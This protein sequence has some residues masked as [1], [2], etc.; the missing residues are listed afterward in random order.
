[1]ICPSCGEKLTG[2]L[3]HCTHC[4]IAITARSA[5][6]AKMINNG[7]WVARRA[8]GGF[9]AGGIGWIFAIAVSRTL[10]FEGASSATFLD[11]LNFFPGRE[12]MATAIAG[13]FIGTVGGMI[14]RSAYKSCLGGFLGAVGGAL[15]G[16]AHPALEEIFRGQLYSY[17]FSMACSWG[18]ASALVGL[19]SGIMEGSKKKVVAGLAGGLV[20]GI[21]G[22]GIGSQM[23]GAMLM[24]VESLEKFSWL[25]ARLMEFA[26]GGIV[27]VNVWMFIGLA[28]KFYI[29]RRRVLGEA[30]SK[31]CDYCRAENG[32]NAWYCAE[33]GSALQVA[34]SR[35]QMKV[36][37]YR[38]LE[39]ISNAFQYLSWLSATAGVVAALVIFFSF[40]VQ[41]FLFALFGSLLMA[42]IVYMATV[43][44]KSAADTI[45]LG[46]QI[47]EKLG[48]DL[49]P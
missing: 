4:G 30:S 47:G 25:V 29:F 41:N 27:A 31:V 12:P 24:E 22:G 8:I 35:D 36:T 45:K 5:Q 9:F 18:I 10:G 26:S 43:V 1:M 49:K 46:I 44:L 3:K 40:L 34:A 21:F 38:G 14:E 28:E 48:R 23:Y 7:G 32:L 17:S 2:S 19:T 11:L 37:P 15:G 39:R 33:C 16:L 6:V 20:G 42:L 13:C